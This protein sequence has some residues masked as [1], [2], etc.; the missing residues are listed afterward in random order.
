MCADSTRASPRKRSRRDAHNEDEEHA[1]GSSGPDPHRCLQFNTGDS[2]HI[3]FQTRRY[4]EF[5]AAN[6]GNFD[7]KNLYC[8]PLH[9]M[10]LYLYGLKS[11]D[12]SATETQR[13]KMVKSLMK[14]YG[15][16]VHKAGVVMHSMVPLM[17]DLKV[18][19]GTSFETLT[20]TDTPY[21]EIFKDTTGLHNQLSTKEA[22]VTLAKWIQNPQL[23]TVQTTAAN[24]E[25][26][27]QQFGFME[28]MRT[29]DRKAYTIHGDTRNWYGGE[30]PTTGPTFIPKWGGQLK[31]DKPSLGNLVYPADHHTNDWQ[32]IFMRMSPIK[33]PN[34]DELKL[35]CRVQADFFLH[36]EVRLP[37]QGCTASLGMLQYLHAP[38]TGQLNKCYIMHTN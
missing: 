35:G 32:Q 13:Y 38:C 27:I 21:L 28:Q 30:I 10:N 8:L 23:V 6:D 19:G 7:G 22:D 26:P 29:G 18:S 33:G 5:D 9:W 34:G 37:P 24:Y 20:F 3:A 16:K 31:W 14:T 11:S 17:K 2:I 15:W 12:S 1:E 4:F 25:D 36:L